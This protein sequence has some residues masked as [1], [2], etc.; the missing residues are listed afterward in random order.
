MQRCCW[1]N[2]AFLWCFLLL[3]GCTCLFLPVALLKSQQHF[4]GSGCSPFP[5]CS[6]F[7]CWIQRKALPSEAASL[8]KYLLC[9]ITDEEGLKGEHAES[10]ENGSYVHVGFIQLLLTTAQIIMTQFYSGSTRPLFSLAFL[11]VTLLWQK[12]PN[13]RVRN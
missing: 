5:A 10:C 1:G 12:I 13:E 4:L 2:S 7:G 11:T 6:C 3:P 9:Y 8:S